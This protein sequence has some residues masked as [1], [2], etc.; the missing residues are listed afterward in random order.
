MLTHEQLVEVVTREAAEVLR[1]IFR[2]R[3]IIYT[4]Q[5]VVD[6][7]CANCSGLVYE[8]DTGCSWCK[9]MQDELDP[10]SPDCPEGLVI[11]LQNEHAERVIEKVILCL[12]EEL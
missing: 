10:L 8:H 12:R 6:E 5:E 4:T 2:E 1:E 11:Q 3:G 7:Y 9:F